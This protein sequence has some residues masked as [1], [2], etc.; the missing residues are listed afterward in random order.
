MSA[1]LA[2]VKELFVAVLE[3]STAERA[4]YLDTACA[5]D[6]ALRAEIEAMLQSHE[7]SG[8]LLPPPPAEMLQDSGVTEADATA[9]FPAEPRGSST[10]VESGNISDH[11]LTFL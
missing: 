1:D 5:G 11:D 8:E 10:Q 6:T 4:S 9:A 2:K 3:M 7:T